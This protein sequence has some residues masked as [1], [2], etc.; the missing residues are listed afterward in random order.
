MASPS[1]SL[2]MDRSAAKR[3]FG[4]DGAWPM[5][6]SCTT[7]YRFS[8]PLITFKCASSRST[9]IRNRLIWE[10]KGDLGP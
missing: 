1:W 3:P 10:Q 6:G 9:A 4:L 5:P 8:Y 2:K 7:R